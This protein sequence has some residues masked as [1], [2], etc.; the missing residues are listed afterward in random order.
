MHQ[1]LL[2]LGVFYRAYLHAY[3]Q[4]SLIIFLPGEE[5]QKRLVIGH[6]DPM[7]EQG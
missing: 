1:F 6:S 3:P 5:R 7:V 2:L 4:L